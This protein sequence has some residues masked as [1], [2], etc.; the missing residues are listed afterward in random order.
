MFLLN[1]FQFSFTYNYACIC[2]SGK[3]DCHLLELKNFYEKQTI[4]TAVFAW[5]SECCHRD[6]SVLHVDLHSFHRPDFVVPEI[7]AGNR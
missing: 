1:K 4:N 2:M 6:Y 3:V 5:K 7:V